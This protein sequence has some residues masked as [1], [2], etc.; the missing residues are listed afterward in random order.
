VKLWFWYIV[1]LICD[2]L[3]GPEGFK[4]RRKEFHDRMKGSE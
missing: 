3:L 1:V 2:I 4:E